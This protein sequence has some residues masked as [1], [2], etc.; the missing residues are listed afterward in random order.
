MFTWTPLWSPSASLTAL[1]PLMYLAMHYWIN[2]LDAVLDI[3]FHHPQIWKMSKS[4][5]V[6]FSASLSLHHSCIIR[7]LTGHLLRMICLTFIFCSC[8]QVNKSL[9]GFIN[10]NIRMFKLHHSWKNHIWRQMPNWMHVVDVC[11]FEH[12]LLE[13]TDSK[14]K[15]TW[16][17]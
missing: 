10:V 14:F 8:A 4:S 6:H 11:S 3:H 5:K 1:A 12:F 7:G 16:A 17:P 13:W 15:Y 2:A 9:R